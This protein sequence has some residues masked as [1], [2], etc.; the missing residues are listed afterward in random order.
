MHLLGL[1]SRFTSEAKRCIKI[2]N[3]RHHKRGLPGYCPAILSIFYPNLLFGNDPFQC[4]GC[5]AFLHDGPH[6]APR[7][8]D[9]T[10]SPTQLKSY[11]S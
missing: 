5:C 11:G 7:E 3:T 9:A 2:F 8:A 10:W 4:R 1:P 6:V